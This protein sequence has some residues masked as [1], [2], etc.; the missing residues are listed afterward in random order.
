MLCYATQRPPR[1]YYKIHVGSSKA[2][3]SIHEGDFP[4]TPGGPIPSGIGLAPSF[5]SFSSV[6]FLL[7]S[8]TLL[9]LKYVTYSPPTRISP[10]S[11]QTQPC[12][13]PQ[14]S[15]PPYATPKDLTNQHSTVSTH[16]TSSTLLLQP[17]TLDATRL[18]RCVFL[19]YAVDDTVRF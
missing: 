5:A 8:I 14:P 19:P 15:S 16:P 13:S 7:Y 17:L 11:L 2:F 1:S 3:P 10:I 9:C 4:C 18:L 12:T 6:C